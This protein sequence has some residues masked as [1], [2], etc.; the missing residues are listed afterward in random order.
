MARKAVPH[1][2]LISL[3]CLLLSIP[4]VADYKI[5]YIHTDHRGA[6]VAITDQSQAVIWRASYKPFGEAILQ[7]DPDG[8]GV[9]T[10][11]NIRYPGQYYD[12]ESRTYYNYYRDYDPGLGRYIQS[13]PIGLAGGL[14]TYAYVDGNPL[15]NTDFYGLWSIS[16]DAYFGIGG[17]VNISYSGGTLEVMGTVGVGIGAGLSIDPDG[18]PSEHSKDCGSGYIART[19]TTLSVGVG[20]GPVGYGASGSVVTGNAVTTKQGGGYVELSDSGLITNHNNYGGRI[21]FS[22]GAEFGSYTN[23]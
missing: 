18:V 10:V 7:E 1:S 5:N 16:L 4:A 8:D 13:D 6:P 22:T 14:N 12:Q 15:S 3:I 11:M 20:A 19:K 21:G 23:W 2:S 9:N 17:G